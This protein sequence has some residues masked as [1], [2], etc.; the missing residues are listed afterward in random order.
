M[1]KKKTKAKAPRS[2]T[3]W[4]FLHKPTNQLSDQTYFSR[5]YARLYLSGVLPETRDQ[6]KVV[7]LTLSVA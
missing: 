7:K 1:A 5:E 4:G 3:V 2:I 6:W